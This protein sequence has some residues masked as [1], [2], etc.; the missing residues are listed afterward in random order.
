MGAYSQLG[1]KPNT[2]L[3]VIHWLGLKQ[4]SYTLQADNPLL[5]FTSSSNSSVAYLSLSR[6][7]FGRKSY[8]L[9]ACRSS[10]GV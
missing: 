3:V 6:A 9:P 8:T 10:L 2:L 4:A 1:L 7:Y 5:G